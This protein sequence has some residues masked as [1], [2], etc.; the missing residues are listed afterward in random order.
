[1]TGE[2]PTIGILGAGACGLYTGI[3]LQKR[4]GAR[5][6]FI[7]RERLGKIL[8]ERGVVAEEFDGTLDRLEPSEIEYFTTDEIAR[9]P[10]RDM[11]FLIVT[12]KAT[13]T[14]DAARYIAPLLIGTNLPI[15]SLQNGV[16]NPSILRSLLPATCPVFGGVF[17]F[18]VVP[19]PEDPIHFRQCT[20]GV[21]VVEKSVDGTTER[22]KAV[23]EAA[24][25]ATTISED[26]E[27]DLHGKLLINLTNALGALANIPTADLLRDPT[28]ATVYSTCR[29]EAI[30]VLQAAG[31]R[32]EVANGAASAG[33]STSGSRAVG[34]LKG[35]EARP[36]NKEDEA[37]AT[38]AAAKLIQISEHSRTSMFTDFQLRR[39]SEIRFL[40]GYIVRLSAMHGVPA[41]FNVAITRMVE[42]VDESVAKAQGSHV[43]RTVRAEEVLQACEK[44][45][46]KGA[47]EQV[48][49]AK[50]LVERWG[51]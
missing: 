33:K 50:E 10:F 16:E 22:L 37:G 49:I 17:P 39:P 38:Q 46:R 36:T 8:K 26:I 29:S 31:I 45:A 19:D 32:T 7:G 14:A 44:E 30:A 28:I 5:V 47:R 6:I 41:P 43:P 13:Q 34:T 21:I 23:L 18:N 40:N 51:L 24:T 1:M 42:E 4:A 25:L 9:V 48:E 12:L 27:V 11:D 2:K 15:Y 3:L 35:G 20:K